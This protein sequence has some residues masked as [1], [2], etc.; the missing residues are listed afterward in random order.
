MLRPRKSILRLLSTSE[1]QTKLANKF[2]VMKLT[3]QVSNGQKQVTLDLRKFIIQERNFL[4]TIVNPTLLPL[5]DSIYKDPDPNLLEITQYRLFEI[6]VDKIFHNLELNENERS[7]EL[8][9][10]KFE[11]V[12]LKKWASLLGKAVTNRDILLNSSF[13][14]HLTWLVKKHASTMQDVFHDSGIGCLSLFRYTEYAKLFASFYSS[15]INSSPPSSID[16]NLKNNRSWFNQQLAFELQHESPEKF[17]LEFPNV[18]KYLGLVLQDNSAHDKASVAAIA[19]TLNN[20]VL[21]D[22]KIFSKFIDQRNAH[23]LV[24]I[25]QNSPNDNVKSLISKIIK[26]KNSAQLMPVVN[27]YCSVAPVEDKLG[28]AKI[29][30]QSKQNFTKFCFDK[31][32][33]LFVR[34]IMDI[35]IDMSFTEELLNEKWRE[36]ITDEY[37]ANVLTSYLKYSND[38][39]LRNAILNDPKLTEIICHPV[40]S[41]VVL[42]LINANSKVDDISRILRLILKDFQ[43]LPNSNYMKFLHQNLEILQEL[44]SK[45]AQADFLYFINE[46]VRLLLTDGKILIQVLNTENKHFILPFFLK[47]VQSHAFKDGFKSFIDEFLNE[48]LDS[49]Y[50]YLML[51][52]GKIDKRYVFDKL[53]DRPSIADKLFTEAG[54]LN[55]INDYQSEVKENELWKL[56]KIISY[57]DARSLVHDKGFSFIGEVSKKFKIWVFIRF[58]RIIPIQL[59]Q[60]N[61]QSVVVTKKTTLLI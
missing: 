54:Y 53:L 36:F 52:H 1:I 49:K 33:C 57:A 9:L 10:S 37:A 8:L 61:R 60:A 43:H 30:I 46:I 58:F 44:R 18:I 41:F 4:P 2:D 24:G 56:D 21:N 32:G 23:I 7:L 27:A 42:K 51:R 31:N 12:N 6:G 17:L 26:S 50:G 25:V 16:M 48:M 29:L 14:S 13:Q 47:T 59:Y 34:N 20:I 3:Q 35:I 38:T 39:R 19:F 15:D 40:G 28:V 11:K 22:D 55:I 5:L 45:Q